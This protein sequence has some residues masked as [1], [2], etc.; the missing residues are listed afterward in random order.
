MAGLDEK[1][2][3]LTA[4]ADTQAA[5]LEPTRSHDERD[6]RTDGSSDDAADIARSLVDKEVDKIEQVRERRASSSDN[7]N[8]NG[9]GPQRAHLTLTKSYATDTSAA[10]GATGVLQDSEQQKRRWY[11]KM[12]PLRWGKVPP[13]PD[14]P[15]VSREGAAGFWSLLTFTWMAPLMTTGYKRQL[16]P[17]DIW[18]VNPDRAVEPM[19]ARV[20]A[21]FLKRVERGDKHPLL[22]AL[23]EA[24]FK[25]FWV[26][27]MAALIAT[28]L[29][30]L[31]PFVLR[32]LIEFANEAWIAARADR[33]EPPIGRGIGIVIG[34][35]VMQ[36][37]Q[38]L[39]INHFIYRGMMVGGESRAVLIGLI[40]EKSMVISGRARA[41][42]PGGAAANEKQEKPKRKWYRFGKA[43]KPEQDEGG[44]WGN[45]R[46]TNLMSVD[47]YRIDQASA[48]F[49]MLWTAP[50]SLVI[51]LILLLINLSYNA[52]AGFALLVIGTPFLTRAIRALLVRRKS[53]NKITDQRVSLTQ[54][55]LHSV[56]F[57]KYFG[58]E[59][60]FLERL[61]EY[62]NKEIHSI[63]ILLA[64][65]NA[66]NAIGMSLPIFASMLSF[67][68]YSFTNPNLPAAEI[69]SSLAL[70]NGLRIPLNLLPVVL[71]QTI[72]A[73]SSMKRIQE[74]LK[75]EEQGDEFVL[76]EEGI[77]AVEL[78]D[79][80]FTWE[81]TSAEA[82]EDKDKGGK[83]GKNK[84]KTEAIKEKAPTP[85]QQQESSRP[86]SSGH[87]TASTLVEEREPFKLQDLNL[88]VGRNELIAVI[89]S[90]G[91]GKSSLLGALAGDM[92]KT[93]G[94]M[95]F[96]ASRA[97][98]PQYAFIQNTTLQKNIT[99]GKDYDRSWY[100]T[101]VN[102]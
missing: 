36:I 55:I 73:W 2:D 25:E 87:E 76:K 14:E 93:G 68:C 61:G 23:H 16:H 54:E 62:R 83:D 24:F 79:A 42:S 65:R 12:N 72:D 88:A 17:K 99:F 86:A 43:K 71:G 7:D 89:G 19:T 4:P 95:I 98:C 26:G 70:F 75:A 37:I 38:S 94:E 15:V 96:G 13:I 91:S 56:R 8:D 33:P 52:L 1:D 29:Q 31:A 41:G 44:G 18:S 30:V 66:I 74:F 40:Y 5:A 97:F 53:I 80:S 22:W 6:G 11:S 50:I 85:I 81:R 102:A 58:W 51:T 10:T 47:T 59:K 9:E 48:L 57:V 28:V 35:T 21:S 46:I 101:V 60:A 78:S 77:H 64:T 39:G 32:Y 49:H 100:K 34:V 27:G 92:R 84:K 90:V 82:S 3:Q 20:K 67:I 45:G 69:F 63:Q